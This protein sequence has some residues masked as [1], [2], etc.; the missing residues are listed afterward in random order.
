VEHFLTPAKRRFALARILPIYALLMGAAA[1]AALQQ[2]VV[3][4]Q[5]AESAAGKLER[6][7]HP[8]P[9]EVGS[10]TTRFSEEEVNSYL[11]YDMAPE[12]PAGLEQVTVRFT[13]SH[14]QGSAEVDFDKA[15]AARRRG[16]PPAIPPMMEYLL[17]GRHTLTV[18]GGFSAI[19]GIGR[20]DLERVILDGVEIPRP[21]VDYLIDAYIRPRHPNF[22]PER[23]F[24]LPYSIDR[25]QVERG[26]IEVEVNP[27][28]AA[29]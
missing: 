25:V 12:F 15:G 17:R 10:S 13:P 3:S 2:P 8:A 14:I 9:G 29:L 4:T 23:P 5:A 28:A 7:R 11:Y 16:A 24:H 21:L 18:E 19:G 20:F 22:D 1:V 27:T 26:S 6:I